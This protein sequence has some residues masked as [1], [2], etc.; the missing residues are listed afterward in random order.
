MR[1]LL[2][3]LAL[4][5]VTMPSWAGDVDVDMAL[6]K[7]QDFMSR[8]GTWYA[9]GR[10]IGLQSRPLSLAYTAPGDEG[11]GFYAFNRQGGG[12]VLVSA[13]DGAE[14]ILGFSDDGTFDISQLSPELKYWLDT[15]IRQIDFARACGVRSLTRSDA[16][17]GR[18]DIA[19]MIET[20]W[21]Q[22]A[23]YN[24][25]CPVIGSG[26]TLAGCG[27]LA[28]AQVMM[29]NR[30]PEKGRG[31]ISYY[32]PASMQ[33]V[34]S[35]LSAHS[36]DW[37]GMKVSYNSWDKAQNVAQLIF[38]CGVS[39]R[40]EY[41]LEK[42]GGS[43]ASSV[44]LA[45]AFVSCFDYDST[46]MYCNKDMYDYDLWEDMLYGEL[47]GG[48]PVLYTGF[49][50]ESGGHAFIC[51][52]YRRS[53]GMFHMNF[54]W[55]GLCDGYFKLEAV[56][57][58]GSFDFSEI[59]EMIVG[60]RKNSGAE[61]VPDI[62]LEGRGDLTC[63]LHKFGP[64]STFEWNC[65]RYIDNGVEKDNMIISISCCPGNLQ[66]GLKMTETRTGKVT[67]VTST[68]DSNIVPF[69]VGMGYR[70]FYVQNVILPDLPDGIYHV[71]PVFRLERYRYSAW[72][73]HWYGTGIFN[74]CT[75]YYEMVIGNPSAVSDM[76][77]DV[78][79]ADV[80]W[81]TDGRA[82]IGP[83]RGIFISNG[84]KYWSAGE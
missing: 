60:L 40:T 15:Y 52:G 32:D 6:K 78:Q 12:F 43:A 69:Q 80:Y 5:S 3:L 45:Q 21:Q 63:V 54:G 20:R 49:S 29:Y 28:M 77:A 47:A 46:A 64:Y 66:I 36:Y 7:G 27:A 25:Y 61:P 24:M 2:T 35:D 39:V 56:R 51:D 53:D 73:S 41:G 9:T 17:G 44:W 68:D 82:G 72:D 19:P 14:E 59:Q 62:I 74:G 79:K 55:G 30:W 22:S 42:D 67:Y 34:T 48:R 84:K 23:P 50:Q 81:T 18:Q 10:D 75:G 37:D 31:C 8:R 71:E 70:S 65:G 13:Y 83:G 16:E 76:K 4:A 26:R 11:T 57:K 33:T 1:R 58:A 38:D